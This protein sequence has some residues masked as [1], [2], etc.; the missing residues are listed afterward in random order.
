MSNYL[1]S[2]PKDLRDELNQYL[3]SRN[4]TLVIALFNE[5]LRY[6]EILD[7]SNNFLKLFDDYKLKCQF[8]FRDA[9]RQDFNIFFGSKKCDNITEFDELIIDKSVIFPDDFIE[10]FCYHIIMYDRKLAYV[11]TNRGDCKNFEIYY[12]NIG[13]INKILRTQRISKRCV[14]YGDF[15]NFTMETINNK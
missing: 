2:L 7:Y 3:Y 10:L 14:L 4:K 13:K 12:T 9:T 11:N 6:K 5:C 8:T 15:N 1:S